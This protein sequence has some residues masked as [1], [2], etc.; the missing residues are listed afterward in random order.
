MPAYAI[1]CPLLTPGLKILRARGTYVIGRDAKCD[2]VIA[3]DVKGKV[4]LSLRE[5]PWQDA[6]DT[7]VKTAGFGTLMATMAALAGA[8]ALVMLWMP[9]GTSAARSGP[10]G[11]DVSGR[12]GPGAA[13]R[14]T[15][16]RR[17]TRR[18]RASSRT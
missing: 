1:L 14:G 17:D 6:L 11:A 16:R 8:A 7:V 4:S 5:V 12:A 3:S 10:A 13:R 9:G 2:I 15:D 18:P